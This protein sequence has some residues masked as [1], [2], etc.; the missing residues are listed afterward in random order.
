MRHSIRK[1]REH[2]L[3][4]QKAQSKESYNPNP[5]SAPPNSATILTRH[6]L[7]RVHALSGPDL[8]STGSSVYGFSDNRSM[9]QLIHSVDNRLVLALDDSFDAFS[10]KVSSENKM[11]DTNTCKRDVNTIVK[12]WDSMRAPPATVFAKIL[13]N[14]VPSWLCFGRAYL[15]RYW[16]CEV[17]S[18]DF[19]NRRDATSTRVCD[20]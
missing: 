17:E 9:L 5:N 10:T 6:T 11:I 7:P 8:T 2:V 1:S 12:W 18:V 20:T 19:L 13:H 16:C 15:R 14:S 4:R 3:A